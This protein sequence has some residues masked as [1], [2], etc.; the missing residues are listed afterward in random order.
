MVSAECGLNHNGDPKL[1]HGMID[2]AADCGCDAVKFQNH[3]TGDTVRSRSQS[4]EV[5]GAFW[6]EWDL[7]S[8]CELDFVTLKELKRSRHHRYSRYRDECRH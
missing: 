4:I 2:A 7:F 1:A 8:R 3:R 5:D 6:N